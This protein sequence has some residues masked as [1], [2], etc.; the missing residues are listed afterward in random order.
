MAGLPRGLHL[1]IAPLFG[2]THDFTQTE[3]LV[4]FGIDFGS[5]KKDHYE[6]TSIRR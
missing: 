3:A 6:P 5:G 4:V 1:D 2:C